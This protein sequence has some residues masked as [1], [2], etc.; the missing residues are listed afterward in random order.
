MGKI[1]STS[2]LEEQNN[3]EKVNP[4]FYQIISENSTL[5]PKSL[6]KLKY[7]YGELVGDGFSF[8]YPSHEKSLKRTPFSLVIKNNFE[9]YIE[10]EH[11]LSPW[12]IYK[13]GDFFPY[14]RFIKKQNA[15]QPS[16]LLE[17]RAGSRTSFLLMNK[18][19]DKRKYSALYKS[20]HINE[21]KA[22]VKLRDQFYVFKEIADALSSE[23]LGEII[24]FPESWEEE[25]KKDE[26]FIAYMEEQ[27]IA[28]HS[29]NM[30]IPLYNYIINLM[31]YD[32]KITSNYFSREIINHLFSLINGA[33]PGYLPVNNESYAPIHL[34]KSALLEYYKPE[35][36]PIFMVADK[37][38]P[39][40]SEFSLYYSLNMDDYLVKP[41]TL[42]NIG[43]LV[44]ETMEA[45]IEYC[46]RISTSSGA[47]NTIFYKV[48]Q[49]AII[50]ASLQRS[51]KNE[52]LVLSPK[53]FLREDINFTHQLI[54]DSDLPLPENAS[55]LSACFRLQYN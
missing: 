17:L 25:A 21:A 1:V 36:M 37:L 51:H 26:R 13:P 38:T 47:E 11:W 20:I 42:P 39:L 6:I 45:F 34:I 41:N 22:P 3:I 10:N 14:T 7:S 16:G 50:K 23:W 28:T 32:D 43:K 53:D 15:Y 24:I 31:Q 48:A 9:M 44:K 18:E 55:F 2:W 54:G 12:K 8:K 19:F 5:I 35:S 27:P 33:K 40:E 46:N 49:M 30:N 52:K 29:Y 4:R